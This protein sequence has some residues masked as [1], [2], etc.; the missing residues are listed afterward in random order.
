MLAREAGE[1]QA[2]WQQRR[3][4]QPLCCRTPGLLRANHQARQRGL[5]GAPASCSRARPRAGRQPAGPVVAAPRPRHGGST[6]EGYACW[7]HLFQGTW[8]L[9]VVVVA[10]KVGDV[11]L[12]NLVQQR[13]QRKGC[14][15]LRPAVDGGAAE[16]AEG[17]RRRHRRCPGGTGG[18]CTMASAITLHLHP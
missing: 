12:G 5:L 6:A 11:G 3:T 9:V 15:N 13:A 1:A 17:P 14:R 8:V 18:L 2:G 7:P 10:A 16:R 4:R